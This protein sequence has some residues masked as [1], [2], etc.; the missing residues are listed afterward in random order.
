MSGA[1][2]G[3]KET[4]D[5]GDTQFSKLEASF[6]HTKV[7]PRQNSVEMNDVWRHAQKAAEANAGELDFDYA[8]TAEH[9]PLGMLRSLQEVFPAILYHSHLS[10]LNN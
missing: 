3:R 2:L 7:V 4:N 9:Y 1:A 8:L 6:A 5:H 10:N